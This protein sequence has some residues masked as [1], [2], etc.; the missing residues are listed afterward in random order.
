MEET[1]P[2]PTE[3]KIHHNGR[4]TL[5]LLI[6][7]AMCTFGTVMVVLVGLVNRQKIEAIEKREVTSRDLVIHLLSIIDDGEWTYQ[8]IESLRRGYLQGDSD[9]QEQ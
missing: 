1:K 3:I 9:A 4:M 5:L 7:V 6:V 8:E 2:V